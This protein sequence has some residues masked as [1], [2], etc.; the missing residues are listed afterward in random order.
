MQVMETSKR[1][2]GVEH[3]DTLNNM[4]NLAHTYNL[5][6]RNEEAIELMKHVVERRTSTIGPKHPYTLDSATSL[7]AW[8][9]NTTL[10][11]NQPSRL[12]L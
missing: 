10:V 12:A 2:L 6:D 8:T 7:S 5:E 1:V 3:P 9:S 4:A 11:E